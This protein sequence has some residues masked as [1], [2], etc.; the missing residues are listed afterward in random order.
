MRRE[1]I[2]SKFFIRITGFIC[3]AIGLVVMYGWAKHLPWLVQLTPQSVPVHFNTALTFSL[4]GIAFLCLSYNR[5]YPV[6][7]LLGLSVACIGAI[8][9]SQDLFLFNLGIDEFFTK[10]YIQVETTSPGRMSPNT[11]VPFLLAGILISV[12]VFQPK[13]QWILISTKLL[14]IVVFCIGVTPL[15]GY[16]LDIE[17]ANTWGNFS[18]T[19]LVSACLFSLSGI[20]LLCISFKLAVDAQV[21]ISASYPFLAG[22]LFFFLSILLCIAIVSEQ[23]KHID[24]FLESEAFEIKNTITNS[25]LEQGGALSRQVK[26]WE[27][28]EITPEKEWLIDAQNYINDEPGWQY[29]VLTDDKLQVKWACPVKLQGTLPN[30]YLIDYEKN[31][32]SIQKAI[33]THSL[34]MDYGKQF[35]KEDMLILY[36]PMFKN[37][38]FK[39]IEAAGIHTKTLF[40]KILSKQ[41][42]SSFFVK[43]VADDQEIFSTNNKDL[44]LS[45][46]EQ[47]QTFTIFGVHFT[48]QVL[49]TS[50]LLHE[51]AFSKAAYLVIGLGIVFAILLGLYVQAF[52]KIKLHLSEVEKREERFQLASKA[53]NDI[54]WDWDIPNDQFLI[55]DNIKLLGYTPHAVIYSRRWWFESVHPDDQQKLS[56]S[57][58]NSLSEHLPFWSYEY[59]FVRSDGTYATIL[60]RAYIL[61][62]DD[63]EPLRAIGAMVDITERKNIE[64]RKNEFIS[65]VSHELRTPL[66]SIK[67]SLGLLLAN[68][69]GT[70]SEKAKQLLTISVNNCDRLVRLI[71][72]ILDIEKIESNRVEFIST[73]LDIIELVKES[74]QTNDTY[75]KTG[76]Q[77]IFNPQIT[78]AFV[79]ASHDRLRQ[80]MDNLLSNAIKFS[81]QGSTITIS[82]ERIKNNIR[83]SVSDVGEGIPVSFQKRI[84]EKFARADS[85]TAR[86][87]GGTGLGLSI[88]KA[89]I[90][91][92]GGT[93]NFLP[94]EPKGTTF[95]FELPELEKGENG[96][97]QLSLPTGQPLHILILEDDKDFAHILKLLLEKE[98][99]IVDNAYTAAQAKELLRTQTY[100]LLT[101]D[102]A[103]P[104]QDGI[105]FAQELREEEK[106]R[107]LPILVISSTGAEM[108][109]ILQKKP[110]SVITCLDKPFSLD[111]LKTIIEKVPKTSDALKGPIRILHVEDE[112]DVLDVVKVLL[113]R[114]AIVEQAMTVREAKKKLQELSFD[115]VLL[116]IR[117]PDGSGLSLLP[118]KDYKTKM[119]I[120]TII[121]SASETPKEYLHFVTISLLKSQVSIDKVLQ[122]VR[123]ILKKGNPS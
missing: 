69:N 8:T 67:G 39:G 18:N 98:G 64:Q 73:P 84:F 56:N 86:V 6:I 9:L 60:D 40:D 28:R 87:Q 82:V 26:R 95:Y 65:T 108:E 48:L 55:S 90:E 51:I 49:A 31:S 71:S 68:M 99:A 2:Y 122:T 36:F 74:I 121:F 80:V 50:T 25:F 37:N 92:F 59:R 62:T 102:I 89:I 79:F 38:S 63:N 109:Q 47:T 58:K 112:K 117:L 114:D 85:S 22:I 116:D 115:L 4:L 42:K 19:S 11:A 46:F 106:T 104:D 23:T 103:L 21:H 96:S 20:A 12:F 10:D 3:I 120:P 15:F 1:S 97:T 75:A 24:K 17:T 76:I 113:G 66:T 101:L 54:L 32:K 72:N 94:R 70:L 118:C 35:S 34:I 123:N 61:Y 91:R 78:S 107:T 93:I 77:M 29:V 100:D 30:K 81:P 88:S 45:D 7:F 13:K 57:L 27:I 53:T 83:V 43:V 5:F 111:E 16:M 41:I 52:F 105:S 110:Y 119:Q 14:G 33:D 44:A